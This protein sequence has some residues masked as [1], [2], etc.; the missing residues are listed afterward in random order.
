[1][2]LAPAEL[3]GNFEEQRIELSHLA[4]HSPTNPLISVADLPT[5][6]VNFTLDGLI[7]QSIAKIEIVSPS[8]FVGED[9]FWYVD[10][11]RKFAADMPSDIGPTLPVPPSP[12]WK[13]EELQV[14]SGKLIIAPK[15]HPL[16]GIPRPFPFSFVSKLDSGKIEAELEIPSDNYEWADPP[17]RLNSLNGRVLFQ[18]PIK[19]VNNNLTQV[20]Q[21]ESI[22]WKELHIEK[23]DLSVTY[24]TNGIYGA[25]SGKAYEGYVNGAFDV[26]L[27]QNYTW[28]GWI[29]GKGVRSTEITKKMCPEY[30]LLDG[31]VDLIVVAQGNQN[32]VYQ[33]DV[34]FNNAAPGKFSIAALND[35]LAA[36]PD[37]L[38]GYEHDAIRI[39]METLR[40]FDY[41]K[42][43]AN[44]RFYGR[45]GKAKL[46]IT[47]PT[48]QRN[49]DVNIFDHRLKVDKP[50][51]AAQVSTP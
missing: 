46:A 39:G 41:D 4:I 5:I 51:P 50:P 45:E 40:D 2:P 24:D 3:A 42:V 37:D 13:V 36:L 30:F 20:F 22:H 38:A 10:W 26:Y 48:G 19:G 27:D 14:S 9:L 47:G 23:A 33:C 1:M 17:V 12:S 8:L 31:K 34:K 7:K 44:A 6:F 11:C 18:V 25:F 35:M 28:D 43:D 16:P 15:G 32:E 29:S 21:V 49:F